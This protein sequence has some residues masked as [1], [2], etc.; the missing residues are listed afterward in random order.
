MHKFTKELIKLSDKEYALFSSRITPNVSQNKFLGVRVPV[1]RTFAKSH[2]C[3]VET[4]SFLK[5][6][7]HTYFDENMLHGLLFEQIKDYDEC[8]KQLD[9]FLPYV[10]NWAVCDSCN[11]KIF[12]KNK[13]KLIKDIYRWMKAKDTYTVRFSIGMLMG[14]YLD[15][16][17]K[18][19]YLRKVSK[20]KSEEYYIKM[21][22][23]WFFATALAKQYDATIPY[24]ENKVLDVWTHN[25]AIQKAIE[26]YRI[27]DSQKKH[28][29]TLKRK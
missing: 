15:E 28:L 22:V 16:D 1:V 23:A 19:E 6:L 29:R 18:E 25:K 10:D 3:D 17:F 24:I 11:P 8:I 7:P 9:R 5:E 12:K 27:S 21:M 2:F 26:S 20:V 14:H 4:E 13:D